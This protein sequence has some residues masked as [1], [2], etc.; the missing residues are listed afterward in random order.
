MKSKMNQLF[1]DQKSV[2]VLY[3]Y[4]GMKNYIEQVVSFIQD[5]VVA[6]DYVILIENERFYRMIHKELSTRLTKDQME[7]V[8]RVNN[9]DF[10]YSSGSYH[11]PA[12]FDY[13][14]K[15]VQPYVEKKISFRSWAHVEWATMEDPLHLI[16]DF[17]KIVDKAVKQ[18]SF[19]LICAY[20]G[21]RMPDYLKTILMETHPYVLMEDDFIV[22]EQYQPMIDV[23]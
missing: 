19:P 18:L 7:F 5:G 13:F 1:E 15:T 4:N 3:S 12:I 21:E 9:F 8:H 17:E 2:H 14:N 23:K 16:E 10:Y 11:P 6:G 22:S 20:E